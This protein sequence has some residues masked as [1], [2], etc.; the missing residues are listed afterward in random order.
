[1]QV[2]WLLNFCPNLNDKDAVVLS[3]DN[4]SGVVAL[5]LFAVKSQLKVHTYVKPLCMH[6]SLVSLK[7]PTN[8]LHID[9][10]C[11]THMHIHACENTDAHINTQHTNTW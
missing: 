9:M 10:L 1:M 5:G 7:K 2:Q 3:D 8:I 11:N 4:L 6:F